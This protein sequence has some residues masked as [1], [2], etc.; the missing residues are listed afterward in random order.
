A[1]FAHARFGIDR[2]ASI[3]ALNVLFV[4]V[5]SKNAD[6]ESA[7]EK[8]LLAHQVVIFRSDPVP[9]PFPHG[10]LTF[11]HSVFRASKFANIKRLHYF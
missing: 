5:D 3:A 4:E 7:A 11:G 6:F 9:T 8:L 10:Q 1:A 2:L